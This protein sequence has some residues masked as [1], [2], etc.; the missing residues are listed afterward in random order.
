MSMNISNR[1]P[2]E[3]EEMNRYIK[4]L[5]NEDL[6]KQLEALLKDDC[7]LEVDILAYMGEV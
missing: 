1:N 7:L 3:R 2:S 4:K 5:N 6:V